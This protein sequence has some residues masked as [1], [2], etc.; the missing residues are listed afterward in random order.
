[1]PGRGRPPK[2]QDAYSAR[3]FARMTPAQHVAYLAA[4]GA[5]WLR[6]QLEAEA[7]RQRQA[8]T[9]TAH[10]PFPENAWTTSPT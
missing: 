3:I 4:G 7:A 9:P 8:P 6:A 5:K 2:G 1:M 10:Q